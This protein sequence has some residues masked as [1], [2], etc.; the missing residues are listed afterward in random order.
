VTEILKSVLVANVVTKKLREF[1]FCD[2][3]RTNL[4]YHI[5]KFSTVSASPQD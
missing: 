5:V 3:H 1:N 2:S 4:E